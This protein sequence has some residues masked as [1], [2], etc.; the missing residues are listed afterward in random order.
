[1]CDYPPTTTKR[2]DDGRAKQTG[3]VRVNRFIRNQESYAVV[4]FALFKNSNVVCPV[5]AATAIAAS[6]W[7]TGLP[8]SRTCPPDYPTARRSYTCSLS[9][10]ECNRQSDI[11]LVNFIVIKIRFVFRRCRRAMVFARSSSVYCRRRRLVVFAW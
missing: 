6:H 4:I 7:P 9:S 11:L 10:F 2:Y 8:L 1:M 3:P 5:A